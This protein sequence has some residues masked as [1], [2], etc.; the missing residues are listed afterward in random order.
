MDI[1]KIRTYISAHF[2]VYTSRYN[3]GWPRVES[4]RVAIVSCIQALYNVWERIVACKYHDMQVRQAEQLYIESKAK[5]RSL[6]ARIEQ[7]DIENQILVL[8]SQVEA[9]Q[10]EYANMRINIQKHLNTVDINGLYRH[11]VQKQNVLDMQRVESL[12]KKRKLEEDICGAQLSLKNIKYQ[13]A[14]AYKSKFE[15]INERA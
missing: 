13:I 11:V 4:I 10:A 12:K 5:L 1:T 9:L 3:V 2:N 15:Q 8:S 7:S 6:E 14:S